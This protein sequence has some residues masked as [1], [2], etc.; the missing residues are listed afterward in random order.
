MGRG[1][2]SV[3]PAPAYEPSLLPALREARKYGIVWIAFAFMTAAAVLCVV[4][5]LMRRSA[6]CR[7][8]SPDVVFYRE[9]IAEVDDDI[10]RGMLPA[11]DAAGTRAELGRRLLGA[12]ERAEGAGAAPPRADVRLAAAIATLCLIPVVAVGLYL[13]I[14]SPGYGDQ[15]L[16]VRLSTNQDIASAVQRVEAHL[17][18]HPDDGRGFELIAPIYLQVGRFGEAA[19]AYAQVL[20]ILGDTPQRQAAYGQALVMAADGVVTGQARSA[21]DAALKS[22]PDL[23]EARFYL[24]VAAEQDGDKVRA[25]A[26]WEK[27]AANAPADAPWLE[28]VRRRLAALDGHAPAAADE[29]PSGPAAAGIAALPPE[30]RNAAIRGMVDGLAARLAQNGHDPEGWL[31]LIRAYKV[32]GETER[33]KQALADARRSLLGDEAT[34]SRLD[35][36][37]RELG[38]EG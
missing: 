28:V 20:R 21:F 18:S 7:S 33:A 14:G 11:S 3:D 12:V 9:Q 26:I 15:P 13:K 2:S 37:A 30:Q 5:P 38:L 27:L 35:G 22:N 32:L 19:N 6:R 34:T 24:G 1:A 36:L 25:R 8:G 23:A 4:W 16:A 10:A 29:R 17:A 31:Q